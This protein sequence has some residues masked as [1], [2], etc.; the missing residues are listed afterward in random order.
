[1]ACYRRDTIA[2][3]IGV[4]L[5]LAGS[6]GLH[7]CSSDAPPTRPGNAPNSGEPSSNPG[8][9]ALDT[10]ALLEDFSSRQVFP[11]NNWWNLDISGAPVDPQSQAMID[12]ISGRTPQNPT[13]TRRVHPDFG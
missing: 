7:G 13:A 6:F 9:A 10:V 3:E 5:W 8:G 11:S 12:W 4:A 1:M 2:R